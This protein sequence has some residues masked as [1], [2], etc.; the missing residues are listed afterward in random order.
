MTRGIALLLCLATGT[1]LAQST[2]PAPVTSVKPLLIEAL[3]HGESSG[4]LVGPAAEAMRRRF[5]TEAPISIHVTRLKA[6]DEAG[7]SRLQIS[8]TQ[9]GVIESGKPQDLELRYQIS[10]C[11]DGRFPA[12][13]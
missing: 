2:A 13:P 9:A 4:E 12:R 6:L 10:Y 5:R 7:C 1:A 8:S 3:A 11:R